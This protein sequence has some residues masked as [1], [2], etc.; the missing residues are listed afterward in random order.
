MTAPWE[1]IALYSSR[2]SRKHTPFDVGF[3]FPS[4]R[5]QDNDPVIRLRDF[6]RV[7]IHAQQ[8]SSNRSED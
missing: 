1:I 7:T 6:T 4:A 3:S 5:E 8:P 2:W